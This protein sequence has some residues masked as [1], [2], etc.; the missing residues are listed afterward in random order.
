LVGGRGKRQKVIQTPTRMLPGRLF[1]SNCHLVFG[2]CSDF[3][4][5]LPNG[6][7]DIT[8]YERHI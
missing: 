8:G 1:V 2:F 6:E 5:G 4:L 3:W 7:L